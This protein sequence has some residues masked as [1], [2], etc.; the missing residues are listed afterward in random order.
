MIAEFS[1]WGMAKERVFISLLQFFA[2]IG[3]IIGFN[4]PSLMILTSFLLTLM[5]V[6]AFFVRIKIKD[7]LLFLCQLFFTHY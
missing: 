7:A 2:S 3:L 5:M 1:R 4:R 6:C